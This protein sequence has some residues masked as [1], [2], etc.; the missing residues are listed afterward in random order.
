MTRIDTLQE[1]DSVGRQR[2][3]SIPSGAPTKRISKLV[4]LPVAKS[5]E[6]TP[7]RELAVVKREG[8]PVCD[9]EGCHCLIVKAVYE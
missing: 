8:I 2:A 1:F 3:D 6:G 7:N 9:D 4:S 5:R